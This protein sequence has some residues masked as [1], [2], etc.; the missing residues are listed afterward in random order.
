ML[1]AF[2]DQPRGAFVTSPR[3][4]GDRMGWIEG[5]LQM[6]P[7]PGAA[8][9]RLASRVRSRITATFDGGA[10]GV[11]R[12]LA[13][14][15]ASRGDAARDDMN[16]YAAAVLY[17]EALRLMPDEGPLHVQCGHMF[18]ES[19]DL[20]QAES[21]YLAAAR[22]MPNDADLAL[23]LGHFYK[24]ASRLDR[25]EAAY[26]R[27]AEL[28]PGWA[29]PVAELAAL[30]LRTGRTPADGE[31]ASS[32]AET[33]FDLDRLAPELAPSKPHVLR[34]TYVDRIEIRRLGA[35]WEPSRWGMMS[36]LRGV[37]AIR[38]FC[39]SSKPLDQIEIVF[40]KETIHTGLLKPLELEGA[41]GGHRKYVFNVWLDFSQRRPGLYE[42]EIRF[43]GPGL[44]PK[45]H[46][47]QVVVAP[48]LSEADHPGSDAL[49]NLDADD[50]RSIE[51]QVNARPSVVR[52]ARREAFTHPIRNVLVQRTD[53]LGDIVTSIPAV[54]RLRQLLPDARLVGLLTAANAEFSQ[55]LGLFDE[56]IVAEFPDDP[57]ERRRIMPLPVQEALRA[58]LAPYRFDIAI[59]L[60]ESRVS[61]PLL[62]LSGAKFLYGYYDR[63]WPWLSGGFEGNNHDVRNGLETAPQST[64]VLAMIERL[65][66]TL[67]TRAEIIRRPELGRERL[68]AYGL[69]PGD[70]FAVLHTGAR[71]VFSRWPGY[72]ALATLILEK[73]DLKVVVM[74]DQAEYRATLPPDLLASPRFQLLDQRLAFDDFDAL[75]SFCTVFVGNDS[76]PKHLAA[77]RGSPVVSLHSSRINWNEWGQEL[78]GSIISRKAPCAGC[79]IYHDEDECGQE[80]ACIR[81][82]APGEVFDAVTPFL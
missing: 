57:V 7:T 12:R 44:T 30:R 36:T 49:I 63:D 64:K 11:R 5:G 13:A 80:F 31:F 68:E 32:E 73:T 39:I 70:R 61:R 67:K 14:D 29:E 17:D 38:G 81:R 34:R 4:A 28:S 24:V 82:I 50:P 42:V 77:L 48:P 23:Q 20:A 53:Q 59:D 51:D 78:T 1:L 47:Q 54:R 43:L 72:A 75:L 15:I 9:R 27:A 25:S 33:A 76:G 79:A 3:T 65:G 62:L 18:K 60:A 10:S 6:S 37:E 2:V 69:A 22:L 71:I 19:G 45:V 52:P 41:V 56:I 16:R 58:R 74:T 35:R 66:S 21:H 46:R 55:T 8:V 26:E 40:D